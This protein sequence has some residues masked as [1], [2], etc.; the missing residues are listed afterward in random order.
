G[1]TSSHLTG[2]TTTIPASTPS[3]VSWYINPAVGSAASAYMVFGDA[4]VS[5]NNCVVF[6]Y[7]QGSTGTI[8]FVSSVTAFIAVPAATWHKIELRNINYTTRIFDIYVNNAL[9]Q[10]N[11]PFRSTT[12]SN[13][14][15]IH[16]Y[17]FN[18]AT[19]YWD[20]VTF[21]SAPISL[22]TAS[23]NI[24]CNGGNNGNADLTVSGGA[25][26]YTY[27]WSNGATTQD[28]LG[29][30]AG[31]YS[32]VVTDNAG[33]TDTAFF[34]LTQPP[35]ITGVASYSEP[36]CYD[37]ATGVIIVLPGGGAPPYT[38]N[39]SNG[40]T[41]AQINGL[42]AGTYSCTI[43]DASGCT[44]L[45]TQTLSQP[46]QL[47]TTLTAGQILCNGSSTIIAAATSGGVSGYTY[48]W[49]D[50]STNDSINNAVSGTYYLTTTD[51][52][53]CSRYD[54]ITV[55]QPAAV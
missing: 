30:T 8:R 45:F 23:T 3:S 49:S 36:T 33:C 50:N 55:S 1:G 4:A 17:N 51:F 9:V 26:P 47:I 28:I 53:G 37:S 34:T 54:T 7:Y 2:F 12:I 21:G 32:V 38:F 18:S 19:A 15:R 44:H 16:L 41:T 27:L 31:T 39:W 29:V 25:S 24:T 43:T 20:H 11:F 40:D 52:N 10:A 13:V 46:P 48:L 35:A 5:A 6:A 14:S 42:T 22:S